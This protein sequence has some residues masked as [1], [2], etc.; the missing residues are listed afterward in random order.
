M[1]RAPKTAVT[2]DEQLLLPFGPLR[3]RE[4]LSNHWLEH[5]LPLEPEWTEAREQATKAAQQLIALWKTERSLATRGPFSCDPRSQSDAISQH[6]SYPRRPSP[7]RP[8]ARSSPGIRRSPWGTSSTWRSSAERGAR[9]AQS[10][11]ERLRPIPA[12]D[13]PSRCERRL[14]P[15]P[16][17][18]DPVRHG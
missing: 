6:G 18:L 10:H 11:A 8:R 13:S 9:S 17:P 1:S 2:N 14:R 16:Q 5:R 4:F 15:A 3:N 7:L 12:A